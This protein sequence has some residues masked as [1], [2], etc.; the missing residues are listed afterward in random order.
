[1]GLDKKLKA[2]LDKAKG[3]WK[4][5]KNRA[6]TEKSAFDEIE[7][8]R[9]L[10]RLDGYE[11]GESKSSSRL[12]LMTA[13]KIV[14]GDYKGQVKR[15]YDGLETEDNLVYVAKLVSRLGY[16]APDDL[17][18]LEALMKEIVG[19]KPLA[20][21]RLKTR[22]EFQNVYV[23]QVF[24][25]DNEEEILEEA[26]SEGDEEEEEESES[27]E[28]EEESE[29]EE[30]EEESEEA[31]EEEEAEEDEESE[32]EE[33]VELAVGTRV[34]VTS[35][36]KKKDGKVI[37]ILDKE[38]KVRVKLDDGGKII[39]VKIDELESPEAE[40]E[41]ADAEEDIPEKPAKKTGKKVE[42]KEEKKPVKKGKK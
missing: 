2:K 7:D 39:R 24:D 34:A 30:S 42:K 10:A 32:E 8:G 21:I 31:E 22:G 9:Y 35:G 28:A 18:D 23:D 37:E 5:A 12:Q 38:D 40:E 17:D 25:K 14:E 26:A 11:I 20:R 36:G 19:E 15:N 41:E 6:A 13:W 27:E 3:A 29:E 33:E 4:K 16:E 1:M